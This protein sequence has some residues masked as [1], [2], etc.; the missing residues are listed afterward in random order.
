M[1]AAWL[2]LLGLPGVSPAQA[3]DH[4]VH[5]EV[6][7]RHGS[8]SGDR[9]IVHRSGSLIRTDRGIS[10]DLAENSFVDLARGTVVS[11][12]YNREG[13]LQGVRIDRFQPSDLPR[14][15][16]AT[17]REDRLLGEDCA[18]WRLTETNRTNGTEI[19]ETDDGIIL[20][21]AFWYP[22][23]SDRVV[24]YRRAVSVE[25]RPVGHEELLPP[26]DL[27]ELALTSSPAAPVPNAEP[28]HEV[29]M[30]GDDPADGSYVVRRHGPLR[31]NAR[32]AHGERSLY[33]DNGAVTIDYR[34][35]ESG[36]PL[37]ISIMRVELDRL[38]RRVERWELVPGRAPEQLL[39]ETCSWQEDAAVQSTDQRYYCRTADG[40]VLKAEHHPH[41]VSRVRRF[42][43]RRLSRRPL[44]ESDFA[45]PARALEWANWEVTPRP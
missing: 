43:A 15:L 13:A 32:Q 35:D 38:R 14:R 34:E 11:A 40:I 7:Q 36:R 10:R 25:R 24:M 33:I 41:W 2:V 27:L 45:V 39:G 1:F 30:V 29:E 21:E 20:W 26:R 5:L 4:V 22:R 9:S 42:T 19:C 16:P 44:V 12:G 18:I 3:V 28:D 17:G 6:V 37:S 8:S 31:S 23:P